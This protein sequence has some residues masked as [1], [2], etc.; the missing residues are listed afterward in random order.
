MGAGTASRRRLRGLR[1]HSGSATT[2]VLG[3][4]ALL[5]LAL[6]FAAGGSAL[7][8]IALLIGVVCVAV[9][10]R[11]DL[12]RAGLAATCGYVFC[13]SWTA[14]Y[15]AG[16]QRPR[17]IL[18]ILALVLL[19]G[20][21]LTKRLPHL[22]WWYVALVVAVSIDT[23][24][25]LLVPTSPIY[26]AH[27]YVESDAYRF[28]TGLS[29][30]ISDFGS[31]LRFLFTL[32]GT[33][34]VIAVCAMRF[35]RAPL[36]IAVSYTAGASLSGLVGYS[37][38]LGLTSLGHALTGVGLA[39]NRAAGFT[40]HPNVLAAGNVYAVAIAAWLITTDRTS[41]RVAG[42]VFLPGLVLGTYA[43]GSRG[44]AICLLVAAVLCLLILPRYRRQLAFTALGVGVVAAF[45]F[46]FLPST[47]HALLVGARLAGNS[48]PSNEGRIAVIN[49]GLTDF[50]HSPIYGI[51]L[52]VMDE[53][54]NVVVQSLAAGGL[55]L[56][57]GFMCL[58]LGG[59]YAAIRLLRRRQ[60]AAPLLVT[61][62]VGFVFGNLENTLTE[63]LV[64]VPVALIVALG[65]QQSMRSEPRVLDIGEPPAAELAEAATE[66]APDAPPAA[67]RHRT[68]ALSS[69]P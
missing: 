59:A 2:A 57:F 30:G 68:L 33:V 1:T 10:A 28:A 37:D 64:Y 45:L 58:Q 40:N 50:A 65:V 69:A 23:V 63:P 24:F 36:W 52:H 66:F 6:G 12:Y 14:W 54:H 31:G 42:W 9:I 15:V 18:L 21:H 43:S 27:R 34:L 41:T 39:G 8:A 53:A 56:F 16:H 55:I 38:Y 48:G 51:G 32:L 11:V 13:C 44:G 67:G 35:P 20:A 26:L 29:T 19:L 17:A 60:L 7:L 22:P 61:V 4:L 5:V 62:V 47:G 46:L 25:N 49:Q 3:G